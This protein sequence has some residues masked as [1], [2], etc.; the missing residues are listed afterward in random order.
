MK[1]FQRHLGSILQM[2]N[3]NLY[4]LLSFVILNIKNRRVKAFHAK[5]LCVKIKNI[6]R[7]F[8]S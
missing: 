6:D 7:C 1:Y 2:N 4:L 3:N 8:T 5:N